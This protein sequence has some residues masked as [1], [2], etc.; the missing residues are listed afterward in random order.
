MTH[1]DEIAALRRVVEAARVFFD[2]VTEQVNRGGGDYGSEIGPSA[3]ALER[4]FNALPTEVEA[5]R[6]ERDDWERLCTIAEPEVATLRAENTRL[7]EAGAALLRLIDG[8]A[9]RDAAG[10]R[11]SD[12]VPHV[13]QFRAALKEPTP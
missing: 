2:A 4:A 11:L 1:P 7:R 12:V 8:S 13:E 3:I 5:L 9:Y 6:R 10:L